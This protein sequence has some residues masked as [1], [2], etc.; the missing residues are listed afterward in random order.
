MTLDDTLYQL[1]TI[2]SKTPIL[3][4]I[5]I[6][7]IDE[8]IVLEYGHLGINATTF[9]DLCLYAVERFDKYVNCNE[10]QTHLDMLS[11]VLILLNPDDSRFWI[12]RRR[13]IKKSPISTLEGLK[14][15][16][17]FAEH[18]VKV[19]PKSGEPFQHCR[20]L[21]QE[22]KHLVTSA[23]IETQLHLCQRA[24]SG[25]PK[26]YYS[27]NHRLW[28]LKNFGNL[29]DLDAELTWTTGWVKMHVSDFSGLNYRFNL[30]INLNY[31]TSSTKTSEEW[32]ASTIVK[33]T[34][35]KSTDSSTGVLGS[36]A[37]KRLS[38]A[39]VSE[40]IWI[41]DLVAFYPDR[42]ALWSYL[43]MMILYCDTNKFEY[44]KRCKKQIH[45]V[46]KIKN[47]HSEAFWDTAIISNLFGVGL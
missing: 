47:K 9:R 22:H 11:A 38:Q 13:K 30:I 28:L 26:N 24:S 45:A 34:G 42:P 5:S 2:I 17:W 10:Y 16:L 44:A 25:Y 20:W 41:C 12:Y 19:K 33:S 31:P 46:Q 6:L 37:R 36:S 35:V 3:D 18:P 14:S 27:W 4:S 29:M 23:I 1:Y 39:V 21:L 7:Q 40:I 15:E 43:K 8:P 32:T